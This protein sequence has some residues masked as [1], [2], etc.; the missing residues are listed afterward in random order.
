MQSWKF[1]KADDLKR[2]KNIKNL[3]DAKLFNGSVVHL[4]NRIYLTFTDPR[5]VLNPFYVS[6]VKSRKGKEQRV[7]VKDHFWENDSLNGSVTICCPLVLR[8]GS[9]VSVK[10][11]CLYWFNFHLIY[12]CFLLSGRYLFTAVSFPAA[13]GSHRKSCVSLPSPS[14]L[15]FLQAGQCERPAH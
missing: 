7:W 14:G 15:H 11:V 5:G 10:S 2:L 3:T 1:W 12:E 8:G 6:W 9:A 13:G 4:E